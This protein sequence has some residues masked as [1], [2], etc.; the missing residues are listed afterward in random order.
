MESGIKE[1]SADDGHAP[2]DDRHRNQPQTPLH[3]HRVGRHADGEVRGKDRKA[4]LAGEERERQELQV[5]HVHS[6]VAPWPGAPM[7]LI[8]STPDPARL[9]NMGRTGRL[10]RV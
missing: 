9:E 8:L 2:G 10:K 1:K 3:E 4:V 7:N 6:V 5:P